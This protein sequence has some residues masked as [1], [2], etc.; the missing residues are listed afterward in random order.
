MHRM[1]AVAAES[2]YLR[3][4]PPL[5]PIDQFSSLERAETMLLLTG[6]QG[7]SRAALGRIANDSHPDLHLNAGDRIIFSSR[8]IPGNEKSVS[9]MQ[10]ALVRKGIDIVTDRDGLVHVSG[11]PR[12]GEL[13]QMYAWLKPGGG[14]PRPW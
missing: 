8:T 11:H 12:R 4:I 9:G 6:S 1:V 14:H 5:T 7:E 10:N 2:G 3:D 13:E